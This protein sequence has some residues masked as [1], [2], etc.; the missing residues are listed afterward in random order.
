M[1]YVIRLDNLSACLW[2]R[3]TFC[4]VFVFTWL[5]LAQVYTRVYINF[6]LRI[7]LRKKPG[8]SELLVRSQPELF[9]TEM[10]SCLYYR[11]TRLK[12]GWVCLALGKVVVIL[13]ELISDSWSHDSVRSPALLERVSLPAADNSILMETTSWPQIR[14]HKKNVN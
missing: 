9:M 7:T 4:C 14:G 1:H 11:S 3:K 12:C 5:Y 10:C 2:K 13:R 8:G 6:K